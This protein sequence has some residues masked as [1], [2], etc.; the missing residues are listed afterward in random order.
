MANYHSNSDRLAVSETGWTVEWDCSV[1]SDLAAHDFKSVNSATLNGVTLTLERPSN[2]S[3]MQLDGLTGLLMDCDSSEYGWAYDYSPST[4]WTS[5]NARFLLQDAI[6]GYDADSDTIAI[7][8]YWSSISLGASNYSGVSG[9]LKTTTGDPVADHQWLRCSNWYFGGQTW[10]VSSNANQLVI[11][12]APLAFHEMIIMPGGVSVLVRSGAYPGSWEMPGQWT[13]TREALW[14][15]NTSPQTAQVVSSWLSTSTANFGFAPSQRNS[16]D[17][18][19]SAT[20][21]GWRV[22]RAPVE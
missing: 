7:Q 19:S 5:A 11:S 21:S 3:Q 22:L 10:Q 20:L 16:G 13:A 17:N 15:Q 1:A 4:Y 8:W 6:D 9:I 18:S 2:C 12:Q 14:S